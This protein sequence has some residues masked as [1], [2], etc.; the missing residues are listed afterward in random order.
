LLNDQYAALDTV[1]WGKIGNS[2]ANATDLTTLR[3]AVVDLY[4]VVAR[5]VVIARETK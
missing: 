4:D 5:L 3:S 2:I 1:D